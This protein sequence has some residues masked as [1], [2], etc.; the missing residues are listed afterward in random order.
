MHLRLIRPELISLVLFVE[1][2]LLHLYLLERRRKGTLFLYA[3]QPR[4]YV[5]L[6]VEL[7]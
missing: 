7:F 6:G 3:W 5:W 1:L 2:G 4:R